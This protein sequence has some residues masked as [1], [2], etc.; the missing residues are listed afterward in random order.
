MVR[1]NLLKSLSFLWARVIVFGSVRD[2]FD[3]ER[4]KVKSLFRGKRSRVSDSAACRAILQ[5]LL[6]SQLGKVGQLSR[7][8]Y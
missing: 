1:E 7:A 2:E 3:V 6:S 8:L 4:V 5:R